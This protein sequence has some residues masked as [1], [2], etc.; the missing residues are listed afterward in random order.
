MEFKIQAMS[1]S[2][3]GSQV[4]PV[5]RSAFV[6]FVMY[7]LLILSFFPSLIRESQ[8]FMKV[9]SHRPVALGGAIHSFVNS[10]I[11][12][13]QKEIGGNK[14]SKKLNSLI[15]NTYL[16][17]TSRYQFSLQTAV[18]NST[19]VTKQRQ[20]SAER[21]SSLTQ[22]VWNKRQSQSSL[23]IKQSGNSHHLTTSDYI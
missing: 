10:F 13:C 12:L 4:L 1:D 17:T 5:Y 16:I 14:L 23:L 7:F 3:W 21:F 6:S 2:N 22:T 15:L 18:G 9:Y 20:S 8:V 11:C 19:E